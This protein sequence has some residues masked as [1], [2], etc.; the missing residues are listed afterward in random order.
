MITAAKQIGTAAMSKSVEL[1]FRPPGGG[2]AARSGRDDGGASAGGGS[3]RW[4]ALLDRE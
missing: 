2:S 3:L 4:P 1:F